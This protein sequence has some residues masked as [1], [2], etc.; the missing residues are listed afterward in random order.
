MKKMAKT[1]S[2]EPLLTLNEAASFLKVH[3]ETIRRWFL[4]KGLKGLKFGRTLRFRKE[5]LI[6]HLSKKKRKRLGD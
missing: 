6:A 2:S 4:K 1:S 5:D 3:P